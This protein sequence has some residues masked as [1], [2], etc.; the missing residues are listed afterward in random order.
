MEELSVVIITY[1][2]ES[3]IE[4]CISSVKKV[5]DEVLVVDSFSTDKTKEI[6]LRLQHL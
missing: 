2:E 4:R 1:N 3:A 5:A 6:C